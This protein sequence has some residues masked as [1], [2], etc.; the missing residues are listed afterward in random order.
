[1]QPQADGSFRLNFTGP[2]GKDYELRATTNLLLQPLLFWDLLDSG[3]F[4][5]G[6]IIY[7]DM[8]ATN[9][10]QRFYRIVVP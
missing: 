7:D 8:S 5:I 10:P 3:T 6:P 1:M 9:N 2:V 4:G